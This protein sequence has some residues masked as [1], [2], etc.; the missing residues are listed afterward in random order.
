[1]NVELPEQFICRLA[2]RTFI[3]LRC[4]NNRFLMRGLRGRAEPFVKVVSCLYT[5]KYG[6]RG[7]RVRFARRDFGFCACVVVGRSRCDTAQLKRA[8]HLCPWALRSVTAASG[9]EMNACAKVARGT[10][11]VRV[12]RQFHVLYGL[13][14][15]VHAYWSTARL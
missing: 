14:A 6:S 2:P 10:K 9:Y 8:R 12:P 3:K 13:S 5:S 1:M 4:M 7:R 11:V 15:V